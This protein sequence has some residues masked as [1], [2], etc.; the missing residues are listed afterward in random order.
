MF[1]RGDT[2][3]GELNLPMGCEVGAYGAGDMP[4][5]TLYKL[6]NRSAGWLEHSPGV[7][8]VDLRSPTTHS[9]YTATTDAN[10][11]F[12]L[13][14]GVVHPRL[15]S[16]VESLSAPWDFACDTQNGM[17]Y[18]KASAN[19]TTLASDIRAAPNGSLV[20]AGGAVIHCEQGSNDIHDVH[21]TGAG[22]C[23]IVGSAP[24]VRIHHCLI[25]YIGGSKLLAVDP[26]GAMR[27]GNAIGNWINVVRWRIEGNEIAHVYDAAWSP[28]G[29]DP[30]GGPVSWQDL[31]FRDNYAHDCGQMIEFWSQG[32]NPDSLGFVRIF[33]EGNRF[34]RA[35]Y[36]AFADARADQEVRVHLLTYRLETPVDITIQNNLFDDAFGA[37]SYHAVDPPSG[38]ITRNNTIRLR[39]QHLIQFQ[40]PETVEQSAAWQVS[41]G[42]ESGSVFTVQL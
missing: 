24:D 35:G 10:V 25:D 27:Y 18:V 9:G 11:G 33:V 7:W 3:Y 40:R 8:R 31:A 21:I 19:P 42:R 23:G 39:A 5:L 34:E 4:V 22:G 32:S 37:Y 20:G 12:L 17:L 1:R 28:Q 16:D 2:F 38:Y 13:V 6:L 15:K 29:Y 14:D 36:G 41:T 30:N 26:G